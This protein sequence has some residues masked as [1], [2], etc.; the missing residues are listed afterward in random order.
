MKITEEKLFLVFFIAF[1]SVFSVYWGMYSYLPVAHSFYVGDAVF[2]GEFACSLFALF[3]LFFIRK[4]I[5]IRKGFFFNICSGLFFVLLLQII[6]SYLSYSQ[7]FSVVLKEAGYYLIAILVYIVFVQFRE[8]LTVEQVIDS[9]AKA[10][11]VCSVIA[12]FAFFL[13][14]FAGI[15]I[16]NVSI[17]ESNFRNG[18]LR[19]DV[20]KNI[21]FIG[22]IISF[23]KVFRQEYSRLDL[24]NIFLGVLHI[25]IVMKTRSV[26]FYFLS[27]LFL[28]P[29]LI[30]K[31]QK[32]WKF[33]IFEISFC[34]LLLFVIYFENLSSELDLLW[35]DDVGNVVRQDAIKFYLN[36][37]YD[38]PVLGMGFIDSNKDNA[39][40]HL[41][42]G[43]NL[44]YYRD[45]VGVIGFLNAFGVVGFIWLIVFL[46]KTIS[47]VR[48][49]FD[50]ASNVVKMLV[51]YCIITLPNL[52]VMDPQ[53]VVML[54]II[55]VLIEYNAMEKNNV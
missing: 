34:A 49:K 54:S 7:S 43:L 41:L 14:T 12:L 42:R 55:M 35:N 9:F 32:K 31:V 8:R 37:F 47:M 10:S 27:L 5:R 53:R 52:S 44:Q 3:V 38:N 13:F 40:S 39:V 30:T 36:Q 15:N 24:L 6:Q 21:V 29:F 4:S 45:D 48:G 11:I 16:L 51:A 46:K 50:Y 23:V 33:L 22:L 19:F 17:A 25:V 28:G 18:T 2:L 20:G 26:G 1:V